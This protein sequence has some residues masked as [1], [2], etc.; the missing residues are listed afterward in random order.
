MHSVQTAYFRGF[1]HDGEGGSNMKKIHSAQL[2]G[3]VSDQTKCLC[4]I[5]EHSGM[6]K[7]EISSVT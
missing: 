7:Q 1:N 2:V 5:H 4:D 3:Q 6:E